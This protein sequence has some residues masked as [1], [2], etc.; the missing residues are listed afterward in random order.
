[1]IEIISLKIKVPFGVHLSPRMFLDSYNVDIENLLLI[2]SDLCRLYCSI[3]SVREILFP[4]L[5]LLLIGRLYR[6]SLRLY[7]HYHLF[8][9]S[10][11]SS[12]YSGALLSSYIEILFPPVPPSQDVRPSMKSVLG[13]AAL[14]LPSVVLCMSKTTVFPSPSVPVALLS[15]WP[16]RLFV[17]LPS[18]R[19]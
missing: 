16:L 7:P 11:S 12:V 6:T 10:S 19:P 4:V 9:S 14:V 18:L 5:L 3:V 8:L 15:S 1:M 2:S 13:A 17:T